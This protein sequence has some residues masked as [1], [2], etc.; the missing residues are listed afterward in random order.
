MLANMEYPKIHF[1]TFVFDSKIFADIGGNGPHVEVYDKSKDKW[2]KCEEMSAKMPNRPV[3]NAVVA[4][5]RTD[6][7]KS[8]H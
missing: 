5:V 2:T 6:A 1:T 4:S 8:T 7:L 3:F